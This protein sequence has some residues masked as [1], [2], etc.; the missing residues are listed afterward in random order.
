MSLYFTD[1][2]SENAAYGIASNGIFFQRRARYA[3]D[4]IGTQRDQ[5]YRLSGSVQGKFRISTMINLRNHHIY[6]YDFLFIVSI[7]SRGGTSG[8]STKFS[9][10][11]FS[12][13]WAR[14]VE[15]S[16]IFRKS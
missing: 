4:T 11:F 15:S 6:N 14:F 9:R 1:I 3:D 7:Y 5:R 16:V 10:S 8:L 2:C 12:F 13:F